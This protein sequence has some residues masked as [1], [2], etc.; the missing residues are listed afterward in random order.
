MQDNSGYK[1][2]LTE[3]FL[4]LLN[5]DEDTTVEEYDGVGNL[6]T[7]TAGDLYQI[8]TWIDAMK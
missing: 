5:S 1:V 7:L 8:R 4:Q 6:V 3:G 2:S